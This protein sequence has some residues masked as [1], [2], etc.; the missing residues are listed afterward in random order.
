MAHAERDKLIE[1]KRDQLTAMDGLAKLQ[2]SLGIP[3][4]AR[5]LPFFPSLDDLALIEALDARSAF[6]RQRRGQWVIEFFQL[7]LKSEE[8]LWGDTL[9]AT[10]DINGERNKLVRGAC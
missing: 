6:H 7:D 2:T 3:P 8:E 10:C 4:T 1:A 9:V 5:Q